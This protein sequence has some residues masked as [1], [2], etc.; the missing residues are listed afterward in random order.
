MCIL[1]IP[2]NYKTTSHKTMKKRRVKKKK[3]KREE[4]EATSGLA[5]FV[6]FFGLGWP[7]RRHFY[8][9]KTKK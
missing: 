1:R 5:W 3:P 7:T 2:A 4:V 9:R 8:D 6:R